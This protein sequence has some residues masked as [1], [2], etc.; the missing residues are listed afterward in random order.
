MTRRSPASAMVQ[1]N[2][3]MTRPE[4]KTNS[5]ETD[6]EMSANAWIRGVVVLSVTL[7]E[8]VDR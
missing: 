5:C 4:D 2:V 3:S 7:S 1:P 8:C 6:Q